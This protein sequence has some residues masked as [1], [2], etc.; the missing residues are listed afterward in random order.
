MG[1]LSPSHEQGVHS[2]S[3]DREILRLVD[4]L[5]LNLVGCIQELWYFSGVRKCIHC[6]T[7]IKKTVSR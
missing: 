4:F 1:D 3:V 5:D 6:S 7:N 2:G